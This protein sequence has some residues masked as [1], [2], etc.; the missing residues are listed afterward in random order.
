MGR[1][2]TNL[3][4][5]RRPY[6]EGCSHIVENERNTIV[7]EGQG[8]TVAMTQ[9]ADAWIDR[10]VCQVDEGDRVA[11]AERVGSIRM[12]SQVDLF[13]ATDPGAQIDLL[14]TEGQHVRA[15]ETIVARVVV[16]PSRSV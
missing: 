6:A 9:I 3:L 16:D 15:G 8:A 11:R 4:V 7:I 13:I 10:I 2:L 12:G 5:G 14:C 1:M